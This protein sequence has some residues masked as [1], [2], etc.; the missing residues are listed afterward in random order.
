MKRLAVAIALLL[1]QTLMSAAD[2]FAVGRA[3]STMT[4]EDVEREIGPGEVKCSIWTADVEY[5]CIMKVQLAEESYDVWKSP[6]GET[7]RIDRDLPLPDELSTEDVFAQLRDR[8]PG[9]S[10]PGELPY[11]P[12]IYLLCPEDEAVECSIE[13]AAIEAG[14][15]SRDE[16]YG[17]RRS[18]YVVYIDHDAMRRLHERVNADV[19]ARKPRLP[20]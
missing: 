6:E 9:R 3:N 10:E 18:L 11:T 13:N 2:E 20:L 8:Y 17:G 7:L 16:T 15:R 19:Q 4:F 14:I 12:Q 1:S 5:L